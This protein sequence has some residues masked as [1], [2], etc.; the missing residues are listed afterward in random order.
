MAD[1]YA[2]I[3]EC[4]K[5]F[6]TPSSKY[7]GD[8]DITY[9]ILNAKLGAQIG[10]MQALLNTM[11]RKRQVDFPMGNVNDT[12]VISL[13]GAYDTAPT[14]SVTKFTGSSVASET[15]LAK[16]ANDVSRF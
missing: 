3:T 15:Y 9:A 2:R 1:N 16:S 4:I 12:T 10:G 6:G 14:S 11:K 13:I 8:I 5:Q 7:P